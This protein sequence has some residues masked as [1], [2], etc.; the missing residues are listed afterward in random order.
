[1]WVEGTSAFDL[2]TAWLG[3][4]KGLAEREPGCLL[5]VANLL[6]NE[7]FATVCVWGGVTY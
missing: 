2:H 1:M 4:A 3:N 5:S 6:E 7:A